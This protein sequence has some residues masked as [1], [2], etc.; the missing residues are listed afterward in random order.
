LVRAVTAALAVPAAVLAAA[1]CG[2]SAA[3]SQAARVDRSATPAATRAG[4]SHV[5]V[6]VLENHEAPDV[7]RDPDSSYLRSLTRRGGLATRSYGVRHPSLPNYIA[8]TS[9][10]THGIED[11]CTG[12]HVD[13]P[14][15]VDQLGRAG[16]SWGAYMGGMPEPCFRGVAVGEYVKRHNPFAYYDSVAGNPTRCRKVVPLQRLA[17]VLAAGTLPT[18]AF[19]IPGQ[20]DN[21]H[22]CP[23][24]AGDRFLARTVPPL[25]RALGRHGYLVVTW[26]EGATDAGCCGGSHGGRI[27]TT[28]VGPDV[29]PGAR[30]ATPVDH[31]GVLR[32][33]E[34]SLRLSRLGE[35]RFARHGSL[36]GLFTRPPVIR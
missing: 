21:T 32:T 12:C 11:N 33:I 2:G 16:I 30:D 23:V 34:D 19:V 8:L 26:D 14:N 5:V 13:G 9:G 18:V 15:L 31:Y 25:L 22:D 35:A 27:A 1:G 28:V 24:G 3:A 6:I 36:D 4:G 7:L 10:S 29:R 20:C 17:G